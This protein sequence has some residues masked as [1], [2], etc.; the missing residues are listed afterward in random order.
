MN[1][2]ELVFSCVLNCDRLSLYLNKNIRLDKN[3]SVLISNIL[4][5]RISGE[6]LQY[7]LGKT[8]F[9][10]YEFKIDR[11]ALIPRP[12]TEILVGA[13]IKELGSLELSSKILDLCTGSGCIAVSIA[14]ILPQSTV[15]AIDLSVQALALARE[16]AS[17]NGVEVK[18][19]HSDLFSVLKNTQ[20]KFDLIVS[21]PPYVAT[22]QLAGLSREIA[23]EPEEALEAGIDGSDFYRQIISE[24]GVYLNDNGF[25]AFEVGIHQADFVKEMLSI[26]F[27]DIRI[28][29]DYNN[30]QRVVIAKKRML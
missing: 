28:I 14:K 8:E 9:M 11:R 13:V 30:I 15:W 2:A 3:K 6:P 1:E 23:F 12:E 17:L 20:E 26:N 10:G 5:R 18:F 25:L 27:S 22:S 19:L 29:K 24:A 21:N 16:N 4:R 7:I